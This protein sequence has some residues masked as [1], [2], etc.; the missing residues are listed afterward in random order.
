[1]S[2]ART[3]AYNMKN[4]FTLAAE[5]LAALLIFAIGFALLAT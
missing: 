2:A 4:I 5:I 3:G 1:M